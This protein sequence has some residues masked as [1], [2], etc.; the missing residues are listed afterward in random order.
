M[1]FG[2]VGPALAPLAVLAAPAA[3]TAA[4]PGSPGLGD[5]L[6][7]LLGNGAMTA[8]CTTTPHLRYATNAPSQSVD[9][10]VT[11]LAQATESLSRFNLDFGGDSVGSVSVDGRANLPS[12]GRGAGHH[13]AQGDRQAREVHRA[14]LAL[15]RHAHRGRRRPSRSPSSPMPTARRRRSNRTSR[16]CTSPPTITRATRRRSRSASTCR[17]GGGRQRPPARPLDEPGPDDLG[18]RRARSDGHRAHA[19][20]GRRLRPHDA[21]GRRTPASCCA[22]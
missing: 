7:P 5:R 6:A 11:I 1:R 2:A 12:G 8:A 22:M 13:A 9:G 17:N 10:T 21:A 20:R 16:T 4:S 3:A 18:L 15:R 14:R 19:A